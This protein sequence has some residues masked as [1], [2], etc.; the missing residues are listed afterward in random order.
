ME[1]S[2]AKALTRRT[3]GRSAAISVPVVPVRCASK[4]STRGRASTAR[5]AEDIIDRPGGA[6]LWH[7]LTEMRGDE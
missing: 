6:A 5:G 3:P 7:A 4:S 2:D 1:G